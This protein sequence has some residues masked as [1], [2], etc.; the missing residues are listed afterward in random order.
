MKTNK[1]KAEKHKGRSDR[2][3]NKALGL[4]ANAGEAIAAVK[5]QAQPSYTGD[6]AKEHWDK[7]QKLATLMHQ[8]SAKW[9]QSVALSVSALGC[10]LA[11]YSALVSTMQAATS[12]RA[13]D[14]ASDALKIGQRPYVATEMPEEIFLS[15][16]TAT[17]LRLTFKNFG[18]TV[19]RLQSI[20]SRVDLLKKNQHEYSIGDCIPGQG[21][22]DFNGSDLFRGVDFNIELPIKSSL[23]QG[24]RVQ[25][26]TSLKYQDQKNNTYIK[27]TCKIYV[28][29]ES[30]L[31]FGGA[32]AYSYFVGTINCSNWNDTIEQ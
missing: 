21:E 15:N 5:G 14:I 32:P 29:K 25:I 8:R 2:A 20:C 28:R 16:F 11:G 12:H 9:L 13:L 27:H 30:D 3:L 7:S 23:L 1:G 6:D 24:D 10:I 18:N 26:F 19:A 31:V 22:Y 4:I 17:A